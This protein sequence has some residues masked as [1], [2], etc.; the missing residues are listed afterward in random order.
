MDHM[1]YNPQANPY[2]RY[3]DP[4]MQPMDMYNRYH[5]SGKLPTPYD[6]YPSL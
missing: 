4:N 1:A 6:F 3:H 2:G 5:P